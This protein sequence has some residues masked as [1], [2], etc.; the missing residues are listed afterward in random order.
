MKK[1][2]A[3]L[4]VG[5]ALAGCSAK[6]AD[7]NKVEV[8]N[9]ALENHRSH[10]LIDVTASTD[11]QINLGDVKET[12]T[13]SATYAGNKDFEGAQDLQFVASFKIGKN[14]INMESKMYAKDGVGYIESP[15]SEPVK[16]K[17]NDVASNNEFSQI[18]NLMNLTDLNEFK[19]TEESLNGMIATKTADGY[20]FTVTGMETEVVKAM[21]EAM[22]VPEAEG[23]KIKDVKFDMTISDTFE[24]KTLDVAVT[25]ESEGETVTTNVKVVYNGYDDAVKL[26]FPDFGKFKP[27]A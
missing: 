22:N 8:F 17:I 27:V 16:F 5:L 6:P 1:I 18:S 9:K 25:V 26:D 13:G 7:F 19:F 24:F 4:L 2:M 21:E 23:V 14:D 12:L 11:F 15:M 3:L 20:T 10:E